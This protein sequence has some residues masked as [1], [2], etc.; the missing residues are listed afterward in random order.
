[1]TG[2]TQA[3]GIDDADQL[4]FAIA[5]LDFHLLS[6]VQNHALVWS[7]EEEWWQ[8]G[9]LEV[10]GDHNHKTETRKLPTDPGRFRLGQIRPI[11]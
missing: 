10:V 1:M 5:D 4:R 8:E 11:K 3:G 9:I 6:H 2:E 7:R